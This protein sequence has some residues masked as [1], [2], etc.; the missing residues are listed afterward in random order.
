MMRSKRGN[1][2]VLSSVFIAINAVGIVVA[3]S[4]GTL[5]FV[6]NRLQATADELALEGAKKLNEQDRMGQ[7]NN[8]VA[9]SRQLIYDADDANMDVQ[10]HLTHLSEVSNMLHE[11]AREGAS[12]LE[13]E[14]TKLK[15]ISKLEA[16]SAVVNRYNEIKNGHNLV[17]P[18]LQ[19][20]VP[21]HPVIRF[22]YTEHTD[23]N[24]AEMSG[25]DELDNKDK[26]QGLIT[27]DGSKLYKKNIDARF[28]SGNDTDLH[29]LLSSLPAPVQKTVSP[30]RAILA[31]N[32][33]LGPDAQLASTVQVELKMDVD[34]KL[35]AETHSTMQ[36]VGTAETNGGQPVL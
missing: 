36:C 5:F 20:D 10:A 23:S 1:M 11:E 32:F 16:I 14:R 25:I 17:L 21:V 31:K 12:L 7:M 4:F 24:A 18:W 19:A 30:A 8:M 22:G 33:K 6:H 2:L 34:T 13:N 28:N 35:G 3:S 27:T 29:F 26:M 9:R 15:N